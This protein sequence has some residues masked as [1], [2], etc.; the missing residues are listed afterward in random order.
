MQG[1]DSQSERSHH[2]NELP[3]WSAWYRTSVSIVKSFSLLNEP[4]WA[5]DAARKREGAA[6]PRFSFVFSQTAVSEQ[7]RDFRVVGM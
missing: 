2:P 4:K 3:L 1:S 7:R 5:E 6:L